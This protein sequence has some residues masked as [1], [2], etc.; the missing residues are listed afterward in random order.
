MGAIVVISLF[1]FTATAAAH[2][3]RMSYTGY[4]GV[5][6]QTIGRYCGATEGYLR[7]APEARFKSAYTLRLA[8]VVSS[9]DAWRAVVG[10][11]AR[12]LPCLRYLTSRLETEC[13]EEAAVILLVVVSYLR[14]K[15]G[16]CSLTVAKDVELPYCYS[17]KQ[18][19]TFA[20]LD[21]GGFFQVPSFCWPAGPT[22]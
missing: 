4:R 8:R 15:F 14:S 17:W 20:C 16:Y 6:T 10:C 18:I 11:L 19:M 12:G 7:V 22:S 13:T 1:T 9:T 5:W 21:G 3:I 2:R